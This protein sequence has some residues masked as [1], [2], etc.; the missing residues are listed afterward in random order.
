MHKFSNL[1]LFPKKDLSSTKIVLSFRCDGFIPKFHL[2][3]NNVESGGPFLKLQSFWR[4]FGLPVLMAMR[5]IVK[6]A[7]CLFARNAGRKRCLD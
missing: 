6:Q 2:G 5:Q 7:V 3:R 1:D 4:R